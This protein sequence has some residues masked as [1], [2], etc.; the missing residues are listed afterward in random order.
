MSCEHC[1]KYFTILDLDD[2]CQ[3]N[4]L[5]KNICKNYSTALEPNPMNNAFA[6]IGISTQK[7]K[8]LMSVEDTINTYNPQDNQYDSGLAIDLAHCLKIY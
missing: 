5:H 6:H 4:G 8:F 2:I 1:D 7:K 3:M